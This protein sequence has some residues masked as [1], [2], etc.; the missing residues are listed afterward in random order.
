M[1]KLKFRDGECKEIDYR[2]IGIFEMMKKSDIDIYNSV[3][4]ID[5][6]MS[7]FNNYMNILNSISIIEYMKVLSLSSYLQD[8][9][10]NIKK[11]FRNLPQHYYFSAKSIDDEIR[12]SGYKDTIVEK[13]AKKFMYIALNFLKEME[14]CLYIPDINKQIVCEEIAKLLVKRI[15]R[16]SFKKCSDGYIKLLS[17]LDEDIRAEIIEC[18]KRYTKII[19]LRGHDNYVKLE[20]MILSPIKNKWIDVTIFDE[21]ICNLG[22]MRRLDTMF[23]F[24]KH[25]VYFDVNDIKDVDKDECF[26]IK[27]KEWIRRFRSANKKEIK[28]MCFAFMLCPGENPSFNIRLCDTLRV[29]VS[30]VTGSPYEVYTSPYHHK[31]YVLRINNGPLQFLCIGLSCTY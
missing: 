16:L 6:T 8:N 21:Y 3:I 30:S 10:E 31:E 9:V 27:E 29:N 19:Y 2:E 26:A 4:P 23:K 1:L 15:F 11:A 12:N 28:R 20:V 18:M 25:K 22:L 17:N 14:K 7:I 13:A 5:T 24:N